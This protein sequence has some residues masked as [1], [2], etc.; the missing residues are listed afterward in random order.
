M[1]L[2][3]QRR[4]AAQNTVEVS[5]SLQYSDHNDSN[6][7]TLSNND[8]AFYQLKKV[9]DDSNCTLNVVYWLKMVKTNKW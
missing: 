5:E 9:K 7:Q 2:S 8:G 1:E 3:S 4:S 6:F